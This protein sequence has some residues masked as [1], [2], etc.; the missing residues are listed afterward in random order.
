MKFSL[1]HMA[2]LDDDGGRSELESRE[3]GD[4]H[5]DEIMVSCDS[6][7]TPEDVKIQFLENV[8]DRG[9]HSLSEREY[10]WNRRFKG[11]INVQKTLMNCWYFILWIVNIL[12]CNILLIY[13]CNFVIF[14][15][16]FLV[17]GFRIHFL[18][19]FGFLL[20]F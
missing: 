7:P 16:I 9:K 3:K 1:A 4:W 19:S 13:F 6:Q 2:V 14:I 5:P 18:P 10:L 15:L 12:N 8:W 17:F 11:D 20:E